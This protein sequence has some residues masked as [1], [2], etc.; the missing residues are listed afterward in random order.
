MRPLYTPAEAYRVLDDVALGVL[1]GV[2]G[3]AVLAVAGTLVHPL[4]AVMP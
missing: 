3:A 2:L 1:L 4:V